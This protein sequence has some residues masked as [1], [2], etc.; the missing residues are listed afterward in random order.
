MEVLKGAHWTL[1]D[2][3]IK[4]KLNDDGLSSITD[5]TLSLSEPTSKTRIKH[6][7]KNFQRYAFSTTTIFYATAHKAHVALEQQNVLPD[8][9]LKHSILRSR[10]QSWCIWV[11]LPY[12]LVLAYWF[13]DGYVGLAKEVPPNYP[14]TI[15]NYTDYQLIQMWNMISTWTGCL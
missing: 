2:G 4:N 5:N 7:T 1:K 15:S 6:G 3:K 11:K 13:I 14:S 10:C 8:I 12:L 9:S